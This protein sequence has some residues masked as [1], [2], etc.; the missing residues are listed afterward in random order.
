MIR[1]TMLRLIIPF[2]VLLPIET[3]AIYKP[4]YV[5]LEKT[6]ELEIRQ[7][8][9]LIVARTRVQADFEDAGNMAFRRLAGYI[10]GDNAEKQKISM[11]APVIMAPEPAGDGTYWVSFFMPEE[12]QLADLPSPTDG[13]VEITRVPATKMAV[14]IYKGGWSEGNYDSAMERLMRLLSST[15]WKVSG[16]PVWARYNSPFRPSFMRTNEVM[17]PVE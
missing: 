6:G 1:N 17:V 8:P 4:E 3:L 12:Y 2:L 15:R 5:V 9:T 7:Y 10:F 13:L 11:T 16:E 14:V